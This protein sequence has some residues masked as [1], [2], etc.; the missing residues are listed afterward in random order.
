MLNGSVWYICAVPCRYAAFR[1]EGVG[2]GLPLSPLPP[3][4]QATPWEGGGVLS[5]YFFS[6]DAQYRRD[7]GMCFMLLF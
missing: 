7:M 2:G 3:S 6:Q 5:V 4:A 1:Q